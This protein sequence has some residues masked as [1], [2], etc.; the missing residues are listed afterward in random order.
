MKPRAALYLRVSDRTQ[1]SENQRP[2]LLRLARQRKLRIVGTYKETASAAGARPVFA[3]LLEDAR[4]GGFD[5]L[6][7]WSIDRF[8]RSMFGNL[9]DVVELERLGVRVVSARESWL[10]VD[11]PTRHLMLVIISW[12]A[13]QE[14]A[15][16]IE[17]TKAGMERAKA[18]GK[19]IGRPRRMSWLDVERA[20]RLRREG[21]TQREIAMALKIPRGTIRAALGRKGGVPRA[22]PRARRRGAS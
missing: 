2:E 7:V 17:R 15:R 16:L 5:Q 1:T 19:R 11:G 13:E 10:D 6:L 3:Q 20:K 8:G 14:R 18:Q 9:R 21:R 22:G 12:V 4:R